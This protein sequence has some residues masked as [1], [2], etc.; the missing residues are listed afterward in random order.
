MKQ[1]IFNNILSKSLHSLYISRQH[2]KEIVKQR[3]SGKQQKSRYISVKHQQQQR[4]GSIKSF[5]ELCGELS[6]TSIHSTTPAYSPA[7]IQ[8]VYFFAST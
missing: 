4:R 7:A 6:S 5:E 2:A 3:G 8:G 1:V